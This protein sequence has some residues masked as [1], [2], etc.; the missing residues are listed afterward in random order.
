[1]NRLAEISWDMDNQTQ[2]EL[3][4]ITMATPKALGANL[5]M[6]QVNTQIEDM[7]REAVKSGK[8]TARQKRDLERM[9][10]DGAFRRTEKVENPR[11]IKELERYQLAMIEKKKRQG[12]L[13]DPMEDKFFAE[14]M[15]K[16]RRMRQ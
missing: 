5:M 12:K 11:V 16:L 10:D 3:Q 9:I 2:K 13:G 4:K 1:M 15:K 8:L 7:A 14:R 6:E